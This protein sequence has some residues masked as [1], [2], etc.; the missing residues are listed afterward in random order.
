MDALKPAEMALHVVEATEYY[1]WFPDVLDSRPE[2][3]PSVSDEDI[4]ALREARLRVGCDLVYLPASLPEAHRL[5][6]ADEIGEF[7]RSLIELH[8][9]TGTL[10]EQGIPKLKAPSREA[11][12]DP[13]KL[14]GLLENAERVA[15]LLREAV[16]IRRALSDK[17]VNWLRQQFESSTQAEP[18]FV[19]VSQKSAELE[20]LIETNRQFFGIAIQWE[21]E[22]DADDELFVAIQNAAA[23]RS[24][25]GFLP[26]GKKIARERL[27]HLWSGG[28]AR[29]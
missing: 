14:R 17:W 9:L 1:K 19:T 2:H 13:E 16:Q 7:H 3:E 28:K 27:A 20:A 8:T 5:P 21:D 25:F 29:C 26:F 23:G 18:V 6:P 24:P 11:L 10:D 22:W 15:K 12:N 4:V